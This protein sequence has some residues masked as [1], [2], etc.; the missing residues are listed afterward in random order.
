MVTA[1]F[2]DGTLA[3]LASIA[4]T[5]SVAGGVCEVGAAGM[6]RSVARADVGGVDQ[7]SQI[8]LASIPTDSYT[9]IGPAVRVDATGEHF[10]AAYVGRTGNDYF[11]SL[12][13]YDMG[14]EVELIRQRPALVAPSVGDVIRLEVVGSDLTLYRNSSQV[15]TATDTTLATGT[16]AGIT[17]WRLTTSAALDIQIADWT[18]E[19]LGAPSA[20]EGA[21]SGQT[22]WTGTAAGTA[23]DVDAP[24]TPTGLHV[25]AH[26][27]SAITL[28]WNPVVDADSYTIQRERWTGTGVPQ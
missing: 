28:A 9:D 2:E 15:L 5:W 7:S 14:D 1:D 3:P 17:G 23:P 11:Y 12:V 4:G 6:P 16:Y 25:T 27:A 19:S 24:D 26:T 21:A 13:A 20:G 8:T 22:V 18:G 10:Y